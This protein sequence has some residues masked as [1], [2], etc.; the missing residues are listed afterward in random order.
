[1]RSTTSGVPQPFGGR[2]TFFEGEA[3]VFPPRDG[4]AKICRDGYIKQWIEATE[5]GG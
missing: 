1:M 4:L 3:W 2:A 5:Q